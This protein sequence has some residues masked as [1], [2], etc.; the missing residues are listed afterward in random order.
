[1][2][3][4]RPLLAAALAAGLLTSPALADRPREQDQ[5][6]RAT[7]EGQALPYPELKERIQPFMG[8]AV[9]LGPEIQGRRYFVK[10]MR[11]GRLIWVEV[12]PATGRIIGRS[13]R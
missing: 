5:A 4:F 13:G 9:P 1:M 2:T 10:F 6:F 12:D 3:M 11:G 8:N 7:N